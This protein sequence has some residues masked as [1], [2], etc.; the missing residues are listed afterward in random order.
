MESQFSL[1]VMGRE[2]IVY[3]GKVA[4]LSSFNE[5]GKFDILEKHANFISLIK[6][7]LIIH[8]LSGKVREIKIGSGLL[9]TKQDKVEVYLG[10]EQVFAGQP[11]N[12]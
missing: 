3:Q 5:N 12:L 1:K 6:N 11:S 7:I 4:A 10:I 9:R 2:G 8:E